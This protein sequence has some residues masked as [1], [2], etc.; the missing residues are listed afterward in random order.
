MNRIDLE[1]AGVQAGLFDLDGVL[2]DSLYVWNEIGRDFLHEN[3]CKLTGQVAEDIRDMSFMESACYFVDRLGLDATPQQL[4]DDWNA[5]AFPAYAN[6]VE[7]MPG[8]GEYVKRLA[9]AGIRLAVVTASDS[10][11][12]EAALQRL[13]IAQAFETI[14]TES[15]IGLEKNSPKIFLR[16]AQTLNAAPEACMVFEDSL[17]AAK[18]AK[19]AGM[20]VCALYGSGRGEKKEAFEAVADH[21][22]DNLAEL[23]I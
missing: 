7:L 6:E 16:T 9:Q 2:I 13:G 11:L 14:V 18:A 10:R 8:A 21:C 5:R 4:M 19:A 15:E 22:I 1:S 20:K 23:S 12:A 17:Y 3:G